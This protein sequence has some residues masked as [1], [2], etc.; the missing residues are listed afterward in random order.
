MGILLDEIEKLRHEN[1]ELRESRSGR[2]HVLG[3]A[4]AE[5][6]WALGSFPNGASI[7]LTDEPWPEPDVSKA[8]EILQ[9]ALKA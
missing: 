7:A 8:L 3:E 9:K 2:E 4:I 5:A 6:I 1:K